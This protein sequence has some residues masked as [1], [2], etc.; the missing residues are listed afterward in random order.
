MSSDFLEFRT[1]FKTVFN[2]SFLATCLVYHFHVTVS[3]GFFRSFRSLSRSKHSQPVERQVVFSD[4]FSISFS[5]YHCQEIFSSFP[6][7]FPDSRNCNLLTVLVVFSDSISILKPAIIVKLFSKVFCKVY[8]STF[9]L[10]IIYNI[11]IIY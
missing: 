5:D 3:S 6:R 11:T 2:L 10:C 7:Y 1:F 9:L 8:N 4:L